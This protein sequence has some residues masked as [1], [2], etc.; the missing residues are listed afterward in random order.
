LADRFG[1]KRIVLAS[2]GLTT[3][4]LI[5]FLLSSGVW[6]FVFLILAG[7]VLIFSFTVS[8]VM[9]QFFMPKSLGMVS[10]LIVGFAIGTG[11]IGTALLGLFADHWGVPLTLWV[12]VFIPW[13]AFLMGGLIPYPSRRG[14]AT[15]KA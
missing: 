7:F 3:P 15:T 13:A 11:G 1:H 10:G 5:L 4:F 9:G 2:L 8:M 6:S 14:E 12:I